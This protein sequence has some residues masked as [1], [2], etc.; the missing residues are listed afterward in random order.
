MLVNCLLLTDVLFA[1]HS[2]F[3]FVLCLKNYQLNIYFILFPEPILNYLQYCLRQPNLAT[4]TAKSLHSICNTC[5]LHMV[6]HLSG[7]I[8]IL[9][10]V[11]M[12]NLP[13]DVAIGLLKGLC[14][15]FLIP[16]C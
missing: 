11:D 1:A 13:N 9:K 15:C 12:L 16:L 14:Y 10:V 4:I 6:K 8:E 2:Y 3:V 7:L 5:R